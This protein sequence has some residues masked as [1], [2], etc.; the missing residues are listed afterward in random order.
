MAMQGKRALERRRN[1]GSDKPSKA[2]PFCADVFPPRGA[3]DGGGAWRARLR[4]AWAAAATLAERAGQW[5]LWRLVLLYYYTT[6][7]RVCTFFYFGLIVCAAPLHPVLA[8]PVARA[9]ACARGPHAE[10]FSAS[11]NLLGIASLLGCALARPRPISPGLP[12]PTTSP[13]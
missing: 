10:H 6:I 9:V 1:R 12:R 5:M 2:R 4:R 7:W 11:L 3:A 13:A 8:P